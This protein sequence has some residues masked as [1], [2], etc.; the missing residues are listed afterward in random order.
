VGEQMKPLTAEQQQALRD[1]QETQYFLD[2]STARQWM[3]FHA[4]DYTP[5]KKNADILKNW[6]T[7]HRPNEKMSFDLLESA[8]EATKHLMETLKEDVKPVVIQ[9]EELPAWGKLKSRRDVDS[10]PKAQYKE[11]LKNPQFVADVEAAVQRKTQ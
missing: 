11:W 9:K 1:E 5:S 7:S 10:I 4:R 8:W 6:I 3:R 2:D